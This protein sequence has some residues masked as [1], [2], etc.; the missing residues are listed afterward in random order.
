ML[1]VAVYLAR[2]A[3]RIDSMAN[4]ILPTRVLIR[5][6]SA[7]EPDCA[8]G[9]C[10]DVAGTI[11]L[12]SRNPRLPNITTIAG[13]SS[14][15]QLARLRPARS[16]AA[17]SL[18]TPG[19]NNSARTLTS[20]PSARRATPRARRRRRCS[21]V[22]RSPRRRGT[23]LRGEDGFLPSMRTTVPDAAT[24]HPCACPKTQTQQCEAP[25]HSSAS[26]CM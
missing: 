23:S 26:S 14:G 19:A 2:K 6:A 13:A 12:P 1:V 7:S 24:H 20:P 15:L 17:E 22:S 3:M 8:Q 25:H 18:A 4:N 10:L 9:L 21:A 5:H 11:P 16:V